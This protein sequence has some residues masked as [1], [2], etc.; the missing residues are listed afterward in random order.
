MFLSLEDVVARDLGKAARVAHR[1]S[2]PLLASRL[3]AGEGVDSVT[4]GIVDRPKKPVFV[5][6]ALTDRRVLVAGAQRRTGFVRGIAYRELTG[7]ASRRDLL[8][9]G[10]PLVLDTGTG[11]FKVQVTGRKDLDVRIRQLASLA[12]PM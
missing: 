12:T 10:R 6:V 5:L 11:S 1:K 2:I 7:V 8:K 3:D 9:R 4:T